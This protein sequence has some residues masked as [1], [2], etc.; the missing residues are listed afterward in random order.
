MS[1]GDFP[2]NYKFVFKQTWRCVQGKTQNRTS[3]SYVHFINE[4]AEPR[5][6]VC[7]QEL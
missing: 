7:E 4:E 3:G 2:S 1:K 6:S 5:E